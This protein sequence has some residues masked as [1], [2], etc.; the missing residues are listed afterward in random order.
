MAQLIVV[1]PILLT[2]EYHMS[3]GWAGPEH[4]VDFPDAFDLESLR[5]RLAEVAAI[6][7]AHYPV[8]PEMMDAAPRLRLIAKPGAGV[9]NIDLAAAVERGIVV[10]NAPGVRGHAVAEHALFLMTYLARHAWMRGDPAWKNTTSEQLAGKTLG[11]VGLGHIGGLLARYGHGLE[12]EVIAHTRTPDPAKAPGIPV[13]FV[14]KAALLREA[15][16][17]VLCMPLTPETHHFIDAETVRW[18]KPDATLINVSRGP[19]VA[20]D[21]LLAAME[22]GHLGAAGLDVTDPEPLPPDHGLHHLDHVLITPHNA[23]RTHE[24]Q[25]AAMGKMRDNVRAVLAG[26]PPLDPVAPGGSSPE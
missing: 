21:D 3:P 12:M 5:P 18:M 23:G 26:E 16:V 2:E 4:V 25:A 10:T 8:G 11:I 24:S 13:R 7:T 15:D 20:T 17:V 14:D 6:I 1:D 19:T 22:D 9:D